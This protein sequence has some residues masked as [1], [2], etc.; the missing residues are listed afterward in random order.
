MIARSTVRT[1]LLAGLLAAAASPAFAQRY[2]NQSSFRLHAGIFEPQGDSR[3]WD[4]NRDLFTGEAEDLRGPIGGLDY[5]WGLTPHVGLLFSVDAWNGDT[6]QSYLD[7]EDD[8]GDRIRHDQNLDVASVTAGVVF[9]F[10]P[11]AA[12]NPYVGIGGGLY[13]WR[14]EETG[15][16]IDFNTPRLDIF[17]ARLKSD[18]VAGGAYVL[19]GLDI[20]ISQRVS[21]FAQGKWTEAED[22]LDQD[23]EGFGKIDL[24]GRQVTAGISWNF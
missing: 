20:P 18:G 17:T 1:V 23:F 7:F 14:L 4:D 22:E 15:D 10:A 2:Y 24:S 16:F 12:V 8:R 5:R 13:S 11:D 9:H 6:T 21:L 19:A 3:Y